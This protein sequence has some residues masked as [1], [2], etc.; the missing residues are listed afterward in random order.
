[1][2]RFA[3]RAERAWSTVPAAA[4]L[5]LVGL[6]V[7]ALLLM[8]VAPAFAGDLNGVSLPNPFRWN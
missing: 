8:S 3:T 5:L 6:A 2:F 4:R 7:V 1:M